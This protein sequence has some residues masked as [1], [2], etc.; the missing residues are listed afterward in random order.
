[1]NHKVLSGLAA[2]VVL[3]TIASPATSAAPARGASHVV[4]RP[5]RGPAA[6]PDAIHWGKPI[7]VENFS[8]T[9]LNLKRW[10]V[11]DDPD[12]Q[13]GHPRRSPK[14]VRVR[15]GDLRLV[16]YV[17]PKLGDISGGIGDR[18][19]QA[20]GRWVIR[21]RAGRGTGYA[22]VILLWPQDENWPAEGEIDLA[23]IF[24]GS[25]QSADEFLHYGTDNHQTGHKIKADFTRW[26]TIA[27]D[28]LPGYITF[29]L[30]G[31]WQWTVHRNSDPGINVVPST[32]FRLALQNDQGCS[33]HCHRTSKTPKY[34]IMYVDWVKIYRRPAPAS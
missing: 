20:Y 14:A 34:V 2:A 30:D 1:V 31:R 29:W 22:P 26:H 27:V 5:T 19:H 15:H 16:G 24:G 11:Y 33:G 32:P 9:K 10:F 8:G 12:P 18:V 23:E 3:T 21:F 4:S 25:R 17:D 13:P 28:W 6:A 7:A